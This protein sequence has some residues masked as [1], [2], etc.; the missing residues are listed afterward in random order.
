MFFLDRQEEFTFEGEL[1]YLTAPVC[2]SPSDSL[3]KFS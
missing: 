2:G 3:V 1:F